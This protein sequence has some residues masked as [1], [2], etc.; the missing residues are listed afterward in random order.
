METG[1]LRRGEDATP[2]RFSLFAARLVARFF[3]SP[4]YYAEAGG[5]CR[6]LQN[7]ASLSVLNFLCLQQCQDGM[8]Y[9][10]CE[11]CAVFLQ[12]AGRGKF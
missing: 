3:L 4:F 2:S 7:T 5:P 8:W 9:E 11:I 6:N 1:G 12:S 10:F